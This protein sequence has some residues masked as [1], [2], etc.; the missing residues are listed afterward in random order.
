MP[1]LIDEKQTTHCPQPFSVWARLRA[2][3]IW[4]HRLSFHHRTPFPLPDTMPVS[5]LRPVHHLSGPFSQHITC[6]QSLPRWTGW[7]HL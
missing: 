3:Y 2:R 6:S 4:L 5:I 1:C 7:P